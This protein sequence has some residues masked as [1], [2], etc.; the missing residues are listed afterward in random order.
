M[1]I[2]VLMPALNEEKSIRETIARIPVDEL[3]SQGFELEVLLVDG[4]SSDKTVEIAE[5]LGIRVIKCLRGYGR[6][7]KKGF[8]NAQGEI[9][10]TADS[11]CS[12]PMED[13]P[14]LLDILIKENLDF[15]STNRFAFMEEDSM[16]PINRIG[17][18]I[19]TLIANFLFNLKL[20]DSQSGMWIIRRNILKGMKLTSNGMPFSQ[21]IKIE[22]FKKFKSKE[23]DSSYKKRIGKVKLRKFIDGLDNIFNLFKR[24]I[25]G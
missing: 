4:G 11:D 8:E 12:Y 16:K 24:R 14:N 19:L 3:K 21:E 10:V 17:N 2:T 20:N 13:I 15:I 7:Y 22:A 23:V 1:K 5:S 6:Q 25:Q 18:K 9:I